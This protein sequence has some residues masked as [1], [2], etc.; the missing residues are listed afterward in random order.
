MITETVLKMGNEYLKAQTPLGYFFYLAIHHCKYIYIFFLSPRIDPSV[1][2]VLVCF[3][4]RVKTG[5]R[6]SF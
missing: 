1:S 2:E 5:G 4:S 6:A 3:L